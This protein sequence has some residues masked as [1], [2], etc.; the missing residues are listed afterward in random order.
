M[1]RKIQHTSK[2]LLRTILLSKVKKSRVLIK[3][4]AFDIKTSRH[5]LIHTHPKTESSAFF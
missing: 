4:I 2:R 1:H 3:N 5:P